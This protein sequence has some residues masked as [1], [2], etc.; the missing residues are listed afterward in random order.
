[1][2]IPRAIPCLVGKTILYCLLLIPNVGISNKLPLN[3]IAIDLP[4]AFYQLGFYSEFFS[5][6][7]HYPDSDNKQRGS[8]HI[9]TRKNANTIFVKHLFAPAPQSL[10]QAIIANTTTNP[11][12]EWYPSIYKNKSVKSLLKCPALSA[13]FELDNDKTTKE[14]IITSSISFCLIKQKR[15]IDST[16]HIWVL[17]RGQEGDYRVLM[18]GDDELQVLNPSLNPKSGY[19]N[20]E[21]NIYLNR[22]TS[23]NSSACGGATL[24]WAYQDNHYIL[25]ST[26][27][28]DNDCDTQHSQSK[29]REQYRV[30][31]LK[32]IKPQVDTFLSRLKVISNKRTKENSL[33]SDIEHQK[34]INNRSGIDGLLDIIS[35]GELHRL[36]GE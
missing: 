34:I 5:D 16:P 10:K 3:Q 29:M 21:S 33:L 8:I 19:K 35:L 36:L 23:E 17:Q 20:I 18:E 27:Y 24:E 1:M 6:Y 22:T 25:K 12:K 4:N 30:K 31:N 9:N 32:V 28:H 13:A 26:K 11:F 7:P 2:N 15:G 14:W